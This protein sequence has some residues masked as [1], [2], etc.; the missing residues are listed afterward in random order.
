MS[1]RLL[2][3]G[4]A[5]VLLGAIRAG[6][7]TEGTPTDAQA[8]T[9]QPGN[10]VWQP[11]AA[12]SGPVVLIVDLGAQTMQVFRNG[13]LIGRSTIGAGIGKHPTPTG[14]FTILEKKPTHHSTKYHEASMPFMQRLTWDGVA[15][16]AGNVLGRPDSH[17]CVHV[18]M[19]FAKHLYDVTARGATVLIT[20][21]AA[22]SA[23]DNG[24]TVSTNA[25][26][27]PD[28]SVSE[29]ANT[30][31]AAPIAN[32][33]AA[34]QPPAKPDL[35]FSSGKPSHVTAL[36]PLVPDSWHPETARTGP[37]SVV[38]SSADRRIYVYRAGTEIGVSNVAQGVA[39]QVGDRVYAA[40]APEP[41]GG[42]ASWKVLGSVQQTPTPD[43]SGVL[44]QLQLAPD[45]AQKLQG[46]ITPGATLILT[47]EPV[48]KKAAAAQALF[49]T[50]T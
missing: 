9:L 47:D 21:G 43:A 5:G 37:V 25:A 44:K 49:D 41:A 16:H 31:A 24:V 17:G 4:F 32:T 11:Q 12:P 38:Y 22:T 10:Y 28:S 27:Q 8:T 23:P 30:N 50:E 18:P 40:Q 15:I 34:P 45:F 42:S 33:N 46:A 35:E 1:N 48:D 29:S 2:A 6:A 13:E 36:T 3:L 26:P 39:P 7:I 19:K 14:I 20:S